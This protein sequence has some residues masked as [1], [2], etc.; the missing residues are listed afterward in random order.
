MEWEFLK[1][2]KGM[3]IRLVP[4]YSITNYTSFCIFFSWYL[5]FFF[6]GITKTTT[7]I[8]THNKYATYNR[9]FITWVKKIKGLMGQ[10]ATWVVQMKGLG[11][12]LVT[13][14]L[15]RVRFM[16][17]NGFKKKRLFLMP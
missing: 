10:M 13:I 4:F 2:T 1:V 7:K 16:I 3:K 15:I 6:M 8:N 11:S 5:S 17:E 12:T 14:G 9:I